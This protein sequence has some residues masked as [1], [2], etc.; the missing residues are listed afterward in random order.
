LP[1]ASD[2]KIYLAAESGETIVLAAGP[3]RVLARNRLDAR[4]LA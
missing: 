3:P 2:G 1:V 4:Q